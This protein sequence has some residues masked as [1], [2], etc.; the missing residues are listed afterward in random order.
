MM[1]TKTRRASHAPQVSRKWRDY[2]ARKKR[3]LESGSTPKEKEQQL[4]A[5]ATYCK[6]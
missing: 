1:K 3:I 2:E 4:R 6:I 5:A